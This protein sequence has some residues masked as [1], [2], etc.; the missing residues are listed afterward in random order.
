MPEILAAPHNNHF[1]T[2]SYTHL[3]VYKRQVLDRSG[4]MSCSVPGGKTK[5][6]L[7]NAGTCQTIS[8]LSDQDLIS[9]HACLLYTS[10]RSTLQHRIIMPVSTRAARTLLE[11]RPGGAPVFQS[12]FPGR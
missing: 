8:L 11:T 6:D 4:S 10:S 1:T 7:A 5:M 12:T 9:V 2:V 3:D